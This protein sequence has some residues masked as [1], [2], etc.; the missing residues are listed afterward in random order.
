MSEACRSVADSAD[1]LRCVG[2]AGSERIGCA[3]INPA[4]GGHQGE[5]VMCEAVEL[6]QHDPVDAREGVVGQHRRNRDRE[7]I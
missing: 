5:Q 1:G 2:Q 3:R 4:A 6:G 7:P